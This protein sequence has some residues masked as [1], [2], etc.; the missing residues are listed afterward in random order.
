MTNEEFIKKAIEISNEPTRYAK[1][2]FGQSCTQSFINQKRAQYPA[3]YTI[4]RCNSLLQS[5]PCKLFDCCGLIK[6]ICWGYPN[7][8]YTSNGMP[9]L[10]DQGIWDKMLEGRSHDFTKI[11]PGAI[12][13]IKGHVGIY[14]GDGEAIEATMSFGSKVVRSTVSNIKSGKN[15]RKWT[16]YGYLK[17]ISREIS[18]PYQGFEMDYVIK[19]GDTLTSIAAKHGMTWQELWKKN[20]Q[21]KNPDLIYVGQTIHL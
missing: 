2:T 18:E 8:V 10:S 14:I 16:E 21:I 4:S 12:L 1:G 5:A 9:D 11:E 20:P 6:A 17:T 19:R 15:M 13:H 7:T 3:W